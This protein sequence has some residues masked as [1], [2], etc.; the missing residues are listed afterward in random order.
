LIQAGRHEVMSSN[1]A[2]S[3]PGPAA[4]SG[5]APADD[6]GAQRV[7]ER[8]A[9]AAGRAERCR[10]Q[11]QV[12]DALICHAGGDPKD[13]RRDIDTDHPSPLPD[14]DPITRLSSHSDMRTRPSRQVCNCQTS[15]YHHE[16]TG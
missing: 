2:P 14:T 8:Q 7:V 12:E 4:S 9:H 10:R 3:A 5:P 1:A 11:D 16:G 13:D 6:V 15:G